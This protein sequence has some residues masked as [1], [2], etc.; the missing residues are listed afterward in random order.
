[1]GPKCKHE[2][3]NEEEAGRDWTAE[4]GKAMCWMQRLE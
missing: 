2:K 3:P 1:M 4:E